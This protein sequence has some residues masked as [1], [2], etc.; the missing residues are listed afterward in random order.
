MP[1]STSLVNT[2]YHDGRAICEIR[3]NRPEARNAL[4]ED[5]VQ[6]L[7]EAI[8]KAA[9]D[10]EIRVI[11]LAGEGKAFCAGMDLRAVQANPAKMG[12]LLH[13][14]S[15]LTRE[16]R[17][18]PQPVIAS[19]QGAAIGGGCGLMTVCD[20]AITHSSAKI[21]YPEVDLGVCPAVVAPWLVRKIGAGQARQLLLAGGTILGSA[22]LGI[23]LVSQL[24]DLNDLRDETMRL[25]RSLCK[26]GRDAI[27][28]TK[29]WLN[30]LDG[31]LDDDVLDKAA[32]I[33]ADIVQ[34][35]EAQI[36]L[37]AFFERR[38]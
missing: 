13:T 5:L 18:A 31:S 22:G 4:S 33:S 14:L 6:Q 20:F 21:G 15:M 7:R 37:T 3:M 9:A 38:S 8:A 30:E 19:V 24:V 32:Q 12:D 25:A 28:T 1:E 11:I 16:I 35:E 2:A 26:G 27:T 34:T 23:G 36:M 17:R 10:G 29:A